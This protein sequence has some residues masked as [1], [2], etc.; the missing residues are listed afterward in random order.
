MKLSD[1][2]MDGTLRALGEP[3]DAPVLGA[4]M[5]AML[6]ELE[7]VKA[8]SPVRAYTIVACV[9]VAYTAGLVAL[10]SLRKDLDALPVAWL[11]AYCSAWALGFAALAH[12]ALV[13]PRGR[14]MPRSRLAGTFAI[15]A[16]IAFVVIG[17]SFARWVEGVSFLYDPTVGSVVKHGRWCMFIGLVTALVPVG[18]GALFLRGAVPVNARWAAAA[19]GAAGGCMGGLMLHLHCRIAERFHMGLVHGGVVIVAAL[20]SALIVPR[21]VNR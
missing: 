1:E 3:L 20:L 2:R 10:L 14:V 7:P 11:A 12:L 19:M 6:G 13:P 16:G 8:R 17:I 4:D 9:A 18:V 5:E 15:G 21:I